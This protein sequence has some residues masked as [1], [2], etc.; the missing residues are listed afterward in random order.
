MGQ[1]LPNTDTLY[2]ALLNKDRSFEGIFVVAV[3]TTGTFCRPTCTARKPKL[4]NVEFFRSARE[5]LLHGYRPCKLCK[6]LGYKG[7]TPG[8]L[9]PLMDEINSNPGIRLRDSDLRQRGIEPNRARR[10]FRQHHGM[11][12]QTF[13]RTLR[14]GKAFARIRYGEKAV[15]AA[16]EAG[17]ESLSGF[18]E[19][20][21][22]ATGFSPNKSQRRE[23]ILV[24]RILTPLGPML[25]GATDKGI[26]LLDFID[27]RMLETEMGRLKRL[28][29]SELVP[30]SNK[31]FDLLHKEIEEYFAGT[32]KKFSVPLL[33]FG[34][35]FQKKAWAAL[36][37]IPYG[38]TRSYQE[39]AKMVGNPHAVR[40]V[41]RANGDNRIAIIIP[42]HRVIGKD[43]TLTGY[44][45]GLWRKKYLLEHESR[46]K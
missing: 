44:G 5:A 35:P 17:Y 46:H 39:Q 9:N 20:F 38:T 34:T 41:A 25:A 11:T 3:K 42:C 22:K 4:S 26:C 15:D 18:A 32:R 24:T 1:S 31:H 36:Q 37:T 13:L 10:W 27:R 7:E 21:R 40:A 30:G 45:G 2:K 12:F 43:G 16:F 23:L 14:I 19:S 28:L 6:P 8:W 29:G 33:L